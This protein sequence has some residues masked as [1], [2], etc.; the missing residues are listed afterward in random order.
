MSR[1]CLELLFTWLGPELV[2]LKHFNGQRPLTD[3]KLPN[4]ANYLYY[5][6]FTFQIETDDHVLNTP[7]R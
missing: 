7:V 4:S 1:Q 2:L 6:N 5:F 3:F